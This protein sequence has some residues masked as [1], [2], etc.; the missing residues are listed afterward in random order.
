MVPT[1]IR[2]ARQT[3]VAHLLPHIE[4]VVYGVSYLMVAFAEWHFLYYVIGGFVLITFV[5]GNEGE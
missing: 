4:H 2:R 1:C 5:F 3:R